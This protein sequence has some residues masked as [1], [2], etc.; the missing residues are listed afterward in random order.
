MHCQSKSQTITQYKGG[1]YIHALSIKITDNCSVQ[2]GSIYPCIVNKN[3][4]QLLSTKGVHISMHFQSKSQTTAQ[5]KGGPYIHAL[6]IKITDN[7]SVQ[8]GSIYPCIVNQNHRQ[9]LST[10]GVHALSI[11]ITDNCSVQRGSVH[12][13]SIKITDNC[14]V[15][16]G[17][18]YPCIVNKNHRQLLST[19]GVHISM[20]C[21]SKSQTT[22]QYKG[23]PYIHA[24][25]IKITD[26]YSVQRGS[27]YPCIVNQNHRQLLSTK[28]VHISMHCQSKSQT[29][30]QYKG[31][32]CIVNQNH[33]QLF[34][35]KGVHIYMHCQSKSQTTAQY[36]GG[37]YIHALSIKITDNCSV[38]RGSIYPCIVNQ[39]H[40]Q[41]LSTKG[42]HISMHCQS[43]SQTIA[44]YK[45]GPCIVNQN[46]RQLLSTKGVHALSIKITDNCSVQRGSVHALSIKITDNCS[47]QRGSI[48]PCIV[49]KNHRQLLSTKG[50]HISMHCQSKSQTI[51]QYKGGPYI[52]ALSIKI[53]DNCSVQRGSI[54]L[55]IVN[56]NH[57]QLLSTKGVHISMHCQ[58]KSD[59]CSVQRGSIYPCIVNQNHRQLL[60]TKG[61][62]ISMHCQSKSQTT[63]QYK[64]GPY[65]HALSIKI[66]DNC[67]VQRGSIYPCIVNQNHRQ[68][69]STKGVHISMHFQSKSQTT[70][71]YKGGPYIHALSIKITDNYSVQRGSIYPCIVNQNHRQ[72]FST[73]GVHI[74]MH[75]QS[76]SQTIAQYKGGPYIHALSIKITDNC[77]VQRGSIYPCIVNQNHRQ[78]LSTKGVH[79]LS[80]KITDNCSVQRGS[81]HALSIKITDNCSVQRG[82]IYPC[83]VNQNHR[84]LLSTKGVHISMHC[85]SK[86]QT[87]AQYK[88]GPYIHALSIKIT[89]N[90][91]V[92]RGSIYPCIFNQNHRQLLSTKGV[93]ISMHCQSKSQTITQ[94][95][96][97]P[98][99]HALS[100]K[101]TDNCSV[102]R[103]SIYPCID[104]QNHRQLLSTKGVHISMHCQSKSQ[105][106]T[107]YKGGPVKIIIRQTHFLET[108][109]NYILV[110]SVVN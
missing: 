65:I 92:Q 22:A 95:K 8:R 40:R 44:Q 53:T 61:V 12:A 106:I 38:Q 83:I 31:S 49:N 3:H 94:Y 32:P 71:Q 79:A 70:A 109:H 11:K 54:Y 98:Y 93:H 36:K 90:C 55:C 56:Q 4:R 59:N 107:Q 76:K 17:S 41:L 78:L 62:H 77:S 1:P 67:S 18:I 39:N 28:G 88:G 66:T 89:D 100:I 2:R 50:V 91:S 102:Q 33:R 74:S 37:P 85:Q 96:G 84:Q 87:T 72:L 52:H 14:S 23:D 58:S 20:H 86:S 6:S 46:H 42:V 75:C 63:A 97:G 103:G 13:L 68:L 110:L 81:V 82:S 7:Y 19:K 9:L 80:I 51:T 48:Y 47:V 73:K 25:S 60:S 35:T 104:Y 5:Y 99:I 10:K 57:R 24:L 45:G 105:T 27:I 101:I 26:K 69:L 108:L 29:T 30:A 15:Q 64:G 43:K 34:S 16:R 21:Q